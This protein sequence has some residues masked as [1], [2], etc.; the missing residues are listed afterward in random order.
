[1]W[2]EFEKKKSIVFFR[3]S[4]C[5]WSNIQKYS[6]LR[7][8]Y[9][10]FGHKKVSYLRLSFNTMASKQNSLWI[11]AT[12]KNSKITSTTQT[13]H[14]KSWNF[15]WNSKKQKT[16]WRSRTPKETLKTKGVNSSAPE[17]ASWRNLRCRSMH[18][19]IWHQSN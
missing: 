6:W 13:H 18:Q 19:L 12:W 16:S 14:S 2:C 1:M 9:R 7:K 4:K 15:Q 10:S 5:C 8:T 3:N 17:Q 11:M